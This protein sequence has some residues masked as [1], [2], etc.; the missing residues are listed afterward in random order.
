M[1]GV[2]ERTIQRNWEKGRMYLHHAVGGGA[3]AAVS[4]DAAAHPDRWRVLSPY[5][6]EALEIPTEDWATWLASISANDPAW[7]PI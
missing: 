1:R 2:S 5:L 7:P 3:S 4:A 6:D